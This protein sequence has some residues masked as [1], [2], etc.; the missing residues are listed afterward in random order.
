[1]DREMRL[2]IKLNT[3]SLTA[4]DTSIRNTTR[5]STFQNKEEILDSQKIYKYLTS[6]YVPAAYY[7]EI[8]FYFT[9]F[10]ISSLAYTTSPLD[11][12]SQAALL[13]ITFELM[14]LVSRVKFPFKYAIANDLQVM[15]WLNIEKIYQFFFNSKVTKLCYDFANIDK[16]VLRFF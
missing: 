10:F 12:I 1:M 8:Y 7:W 3:D 16:I 13:I 9:N 15:S 14:L 2:E 4:N 11:P 6:D 5:K